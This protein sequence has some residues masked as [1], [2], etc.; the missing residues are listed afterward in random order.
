MHLVI[1]APA[2]VVSLVDARG[3]QF[4]VLPQQGQFSR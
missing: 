4:E 2:A 3:W 1:F